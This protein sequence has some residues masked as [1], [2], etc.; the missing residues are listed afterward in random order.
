M[1]LGSFMG[2]LWLSQP[3]FRSIQ[4]QNLAQRGLT[5][6]FILI[7]LAIGLYINVFQFFLAAEVVHDEVLALIGVYTHV[8][9]HNS[10]E[11]L[12]HHL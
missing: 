11:H 2:P 5:L 1:A 12:V 10:G 3:I 7:L 6:V 9:L 4:P 8:E